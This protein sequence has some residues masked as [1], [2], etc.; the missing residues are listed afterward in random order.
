MQTRCWLITLI[1]S[2]ALG[3][4]QVASDADLS[5]ARWI[6][7]LESA[8]PDSMPVS[9]SSSSEEEEPI[10]SLESTEGESRTLGADEDSP[11]AKVFIPDIGKIKTIVEI[12]KTVGDVVVPVILEEVESVAGNVA[13]TISGSG[14]AG[15]V[16]GQLQAVNVPEDLVAFK[17]R[18]VMLLQGAKKDF[19][20]FRPRVIS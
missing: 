16:Q 8:A 2:V 7:A 1:I 5:V 19:G 13:G 17:T 12:L 18:G 15:E 11:T 14:A 9:D 4:P 20:N 3:Q 6:L 10:P